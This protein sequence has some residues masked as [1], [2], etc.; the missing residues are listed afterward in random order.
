MRQNTLS[1]SATI[2]GIAQRAYLSVLETSQFSSGQGISLQIV[3]FEKLEVLTTG[4]DKS[5]RLSN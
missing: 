1:V 4:F 5:T 2:S 3:D